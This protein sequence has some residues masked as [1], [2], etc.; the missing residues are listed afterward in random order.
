MDNIAFLYTTDHPIVRVV[1]A[2]DYFDAEAMYKKF[3]AAG[4]TDKE[5]I[6]IINTDDLALRDLQH[7]CSFLEVEP[8]CNFSVISKEELRR[9]TNAMIGYGKRWKFSTAFTNDAHAL[10]QEK[11]IQGRP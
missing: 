11:E 7:V 1:D 10:A 6:R 4:P 9:L 5:F 2:G 8:P 3:L